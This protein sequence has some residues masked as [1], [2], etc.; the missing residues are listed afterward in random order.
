MPCHLEYKEQLIIR[1]TGEERPDCW[2]SKARSPCRELPFAATQA[3]GAQ[4]EEDKGS[5]VSLFR[6]I[7]LALSCQ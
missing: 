6:K 2:S 1:I 4:F 3:S 5:V 7:A